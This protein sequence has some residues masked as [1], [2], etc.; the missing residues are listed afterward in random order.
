MMN[1]AHANEQEQGQRESRETAPSGPRV[2]R[3]HQASAICAGVAFLRAPTSR[4]RSM[5]ALFAVMASG[6]NRGKVARR[7]AFGSNVMPELTV[8]VR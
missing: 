1:P 5:T 4:S 7:S 6:V 8:P 2:D 3:E